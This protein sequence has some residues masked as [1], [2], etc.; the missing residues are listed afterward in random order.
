MADP[1]LGPFLALVHPTQDSP[2]RIDK[3]LRAS[4][5]RGSPELVLSTWHSAIFLDLGL[6]QAS[7]Q[8]DGIPSKAKAGGWG[9]VLASGSG[10]VIWQLC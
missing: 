7:D 10:P 9:L 6:Q 1:G 2:C 8:E 4:Q 3:Q 5:P